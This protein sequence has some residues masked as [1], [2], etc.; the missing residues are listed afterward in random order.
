[1]RR[2]AAAL[3]AL[4]PSGLYL[5]L[6]VLVTVVML[7]GAVATAWITDARLAARQHD[8]I[9]HQALALARNAAD[10]VAQESAL[11]AIGSIDPRLQQIAQLPGIDSL[12]ILS[13]QGERLSGWRRLHPQAEP[14]FDTVRAR[15]PLP[16]QGVAH[17]EH[18]DDEV[19]VVAWAPIGSAAD[20]GWIRLERSLD[21]TRATERDTLITSISSSLLV[22]IL[23]IGLLAGYLR[24]AL[25]PLESAARFA[26]QLA[27]HPGSTLAVRGSAR[28]VRALTHALNDASLTLRE[29]YD[30]LLKR[31]TELATLLETAADAVVGVDDQG[32]ILM[33]NAAATSIFGLS[34]EQAQGRPLF[35]LVPALTTQRLGELIADGVQVGSRGMRLARLDASGLRNGGTEFPVDVAVGAVAAS[36]SSSLRYALMIRDVTEMRM[37]DDTLRLYVRALENSNSGIVICDARLPGAPMMYANAAFTA[38]TGYPAHDAIGRTCSFLQGKDRS[39]PA[40][41]ELRAAIAAGRPAVVTLRNYRKDGTPFWNQLTVAPVRDDTGQLTHFVGAINDI[42]VRVEAE[43]A[44]ER[45][46][47]QLDLILQLSPDGFV[48][49]DGDDRLVYANAAFQRMTGLSPAQLGTEVHPALLEERLRA[50]A[51]PKLA[52]PPLWRVDPDPHERVLMQPERRI[53]LTQVASSGTD[54]VLFV[55]DVTAETEVDRMKSEF[56]STAAHELRTPMVSIYGF[57]ELLLKRNYPPEKQRPM[58]ETIHRQSALIVNLVNELLDLARIEARQGKDFHVAVQPLAPIVREAVA[59]LMIPSDP[60]KVDLHIDDDAVQVAVD[61]DKL[62]QALG[63]VLSNAYKYSP[64]GGAIDVRVRQRPH[65]AGVEGSGDGG[66]EVGIEVRD[67]GIGMTAEQLARAFDRFYRAD[68]SGNIPG[69]G[70]GL[71]IVKEIVELLGGRVQIDSQAGNGTVVTLWLPQA[72]AATGPSARALALQA[73]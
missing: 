11:G 28:E 60:R 68:P 63:N 65:G 55:R 71:C 56:L 58:V 67:H 38:I 52:W 40:V 47:E 62:R 14:L 5:R 15:A 1:M 37:A 4:R 29:Q 70:L 64:A 72:A 12:S 13:A 49:F 32:R 39:Q 41:A 31:D 54:R 69:T 24:R 46:S 59:G 17:V 2:L 22:A 66:S 51:D 30:A 43:L 42:T 57:A 36:G 53:L 33:F 10:A 73:E 25:S 35:A 21:A 48:L 23:V 27:A 8:A 3:R 20:G 45:R 50:L 16:T 61:S 7:V 9:E 19:A 44:S 18:H 26:K 34:A 6:L